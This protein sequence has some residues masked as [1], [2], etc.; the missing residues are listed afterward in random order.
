MNKIEGT[1]NLFCNCSSVCCQGGYFCRTPGIYDQSAVMQC[2]EDTNASSESRGVGWLRWHLKSQLL[3]R[4]CG[5]CGGGD[6]GCVIVVWGFDVG[7]N[8]NVVGIVIIARVSSQTR[9]YFLPYSDT[10]KRKRPIEINRAGWRARCAFCAAA[11][12]Q[13]LCWLWMLGGGNYLWQACGT[14]NV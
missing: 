12:A 2:S 5:A 6:C 1:F 10:N 14:R 3:L 8:V 13:V 4:L 11:C 9:R 7:V